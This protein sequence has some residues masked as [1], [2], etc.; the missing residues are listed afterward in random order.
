MPES[1][2]HLF[3]G[4][5]TYLTVA[6]YFRS[7]LG[8]I[9]NGSC[10]LRIYNGASVITPSVL[11]L[12]ERECP[13]MA[14]RVLLVDD[15]AVIRRALIESFSAEPDFEVCGEAENGQQAIEIAEK[16]VPDLIVMDLSMPVMNG[17]AAAR[18]LKTLL[19]AVALIIFSGYSDVFSKREA[20][21]AGV[22][23]LVSKSEHLS[24][25]V[26]KARSLVDESL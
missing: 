9:E 21:S 24:V 17:I 19:P 8:F 4:L 7:D 13:Q 3:P 20:Q 15:N 12:F 26:S 22:S 10:H 23:A 6:D 1:L 14:K 2:L 16:L 18:V 5:S 25:L 11:N